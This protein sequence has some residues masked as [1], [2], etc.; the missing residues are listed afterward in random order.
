MTVL[1]NS[2]FRTIKKLAR[3]DAV[4]RAEFRAW[5]LSKAMWK[6]ALQAVEDWFTSGFSTTPS[7]SLKVAIEAQTGACTNAQAKQVAKV[8]S[9]WR[10]GDEKGT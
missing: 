9:G 5:G 10:Y 8:W 6:A 3:Q 4:A 2:D 1:D 7:T